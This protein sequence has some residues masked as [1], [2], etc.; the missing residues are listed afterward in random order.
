MSRY[1]E[2]TVNNLMKAHKAGVRIAMG[3]DAG[4]HDP[5]NNGAFLEMEYMSDAGMSNVDVIHASTCLAAQKGRI[6]DIT[7]TLVAGKEADLL[8]VDGNPLDDI[9]ILKDE[10]RKKLVLKS[11][12]PV[13][14]TWTE[15]NLANMPLGE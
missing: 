11:G 4:L 12:S 10:S 1:Y 9:R 13:G 5:E 14:G 7:G 3:S 15:R 2:M 6:D 8:I